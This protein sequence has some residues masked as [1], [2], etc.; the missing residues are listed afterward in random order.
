M[1][2]SLASAARTALSAVVFDVDGTLYDTRRMRLSLLAG[3]IGRAV[4]RPAE[5]A[6]AVAIVRAYRRVHEGLRGARHADLAGE[7]LRRTASATGRT[8]EEVAR[9]VGV[10][11]EE[12]PLR[13]VAA[14]LRP[15]LARSLERLRRSDVRT[16]VLSDYPPLLKLEAMGVATLFDGVAWAQQPSIGALKPEPAG[17]LS[18]LETLGVP[19]ERAVY[20]GDRPDVDEVVAR[21][22][23]CRAAII[24][25]RRPRGADTPH[26]TDVSALADWVLRLRD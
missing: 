20:V 26:F 8:E 11:F 16:G 1:A 22:A 14:A 3:M 13:A 4:G 12:L 23:G 5:A 2:R 15:D 9:A 21:A 10:W 17:L 25:P 18:L 6:S 7:Q 24:G 19:P